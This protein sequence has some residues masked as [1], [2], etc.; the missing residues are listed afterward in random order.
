MSI[1]SENRAVLAGR[2][3]RLAT[4][5]N[6][7][8]RR[9]DLLVEDGRRGEPTA[10][11]R[12]NGEP[13]PYL[14]SRVD[15]RTEARR[16]AT[17]ISAAVGYVVVWG[18]GLFYEI[19][20]LL[21]RPELAYLLVLEPRPTFLRAALESRD[22]RPALSDPRLH[23]RTGIHAEPDSAAKTVSETYLPVIHGAFHIE[24][25]RPRAEESRE[26]LA[27]LGA[28]AR[29]QLA[30]MA[31]QQ[32]FGRRWFSNAI[33]NLAT[34]S[35][36]GVDFPA[37]DT[38]VVAAAGP[39]LEEQVADLD[40]RVPIISTDT[41]AP[42]LLQRGIR[43]AVL[44]S[45]DCQQVSYH[46]LLTGGAALRR[47]P[48]M[49]DLSTPP[50]VLHHAAR[51]VLATTGYPLARLLRRRFSELPII[52]GA[53]GNVTQAAVSVAVS[54]GARRVHLLGADLAYPDGAPYARDS[55]LYPHFRSTETRLHPT[56]SALMEMV[57]ADPQTA[58]AEE[59]GRRVYRPPR[60]SRYRKNLEEQISTLDAEVVFGPP[61]AA[62]AAEPTRRGAPGGARRRSDS[63][64]GSNG[65]VLRFAVP[66]ISSRVDWLNEYGEEVS[67][68]SVPAGAAAGQI[69][70]P[71]D[72]QRELWYS[73]LPAAAAF[74][75]DEL[76]VRRTP[77]VLETALRWTVERLSRVT[78]THAAKPTP[79]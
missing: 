42:A 18:P 38:M 6:S 73:I 59:A 78:A 27:A 16:A 69:G 29:G 66:P 60:L 35:P 36:A 52:D 23:I 51:A 24:G 75:G 44:V 71:G 58:S 2:H 48:L 11:L 62:A 8:Y 15:P 79:P 9:S 30:D 40:S 47:V 46:H 68:L 4:E 32:R 34:L 21:E 56:Q 64:H 53:G 13:G 26:T 20:V 57:L 50:T 43:P 5:L 33:R 63:R 67:A 3:G 12:V 45:L 77:A 61:A 22:L 72:E 49:A 70:E 39:S 10:R 7:A 28:A 37:A 76:D 25:A 74:V 14:H 19:E 54:L 65:D 41:A 31:V 1:F 17:A 55:Y